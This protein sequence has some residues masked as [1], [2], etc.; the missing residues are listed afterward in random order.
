M[1]AEKEREEARRIEETGYSERDKREH[2][3]E[4]SDGGE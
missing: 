1:K 4:D 2:E 3:D